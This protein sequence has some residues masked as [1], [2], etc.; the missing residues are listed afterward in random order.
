MSISG[1]PN[2]VSK[3][4][5]ERTTCFCDESAAYKNC[6]ILHASSCARFDR[7]YHFI[8]AIVIIVTFVQP[9]GSQNSRSGN[10]FGAMSDQR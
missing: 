8:A 7:Y 4:S 2:Q 6:Y 10:T 3:T 9:G 5:D 1:S